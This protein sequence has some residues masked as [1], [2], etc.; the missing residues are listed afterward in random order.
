MSLLST[1]ENPQPGMLVG[2]LRD[3]RR[4]E[5]L[6]RLND[7]Q[8]KR[9]AWRAKDSM[10]GQH[11]LVEIIP[12]DSSPYSVLEGEGDIL[13]TL[14]GYA[15]PFPPTG[16]KPAA[17]HPGQQHIVD[18]IDGFSLP[19]RTRGNDEELGSDDAVITELLGPSLRDW[20]LARPA[21]FFPP[22]LVQRIALQLLTALDHL[23]TLRDVLEYRVAHLDQQKLEI[24]E[25][26]D[27]L[28]LK[29]SNF[30]SAIR[31]VH[32]G[33]DSH[34][35]HA[36]RQTAAPEQLLL[37]EGYG[38]YGPARAADIWAVGVVVSLLLFNKHLAF[39]NLD[40]SWQRINLRDPLTRYNVKPEVIV[41]LASLN[42]EEPW[43]DSYMDSLRLY[44]DPGYPFDIPGVEPM[45]TLRERVEAQGK[46][47]NPAEVDKLVSF[48]RA[49]WTL[50]PYT[51]PSAKELL[52]H[53]WLE[54][55][56]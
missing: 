24:D 44:P 15:E 51:R 25:P 48:L 8:E 10:N 2:R 32:L 20:Q 6:E 33:E 46:I 13:W 26:A 31:D 43:P 54:G 35:W 39:D 41:S 53:E 12:S 50:D 55:V 11:V 5:L 22:Y 42:K 29:L 38:S 28:Q 37:Y 16:P 34:H 45:P 27:T 1:D 36:T 47:D 14:A 49:C 7:P 52:Q 3:I 40:F 9:S 23:Q 56:A 21:P 4:F 30:G 17:S 18:I 19:D